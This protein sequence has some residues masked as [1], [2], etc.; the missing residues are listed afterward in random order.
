MPNVTDAT[1]VLNWLVRRLAIDMDD[2]Y[3]PGERVSFSIEAFRPVF[4]A[5]SVK[6]S[7]TEEDGRYACWLRGF[8][9]QMQDDL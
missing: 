4:K 5:S 1:D 3:E 7:A 6:V 2:M 9:D 8:L